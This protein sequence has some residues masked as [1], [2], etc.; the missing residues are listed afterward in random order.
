MLGIAWGTLD[1]LALRGA[2]GRFRVARPPE[3]EAARLAVVRD[4]PHGA[5][6]RPSASPR[7]PLSALRD[8]GQ[9]P[10]PLAPSLRR[11]GGGARSGFLG[12]LS[13]ELSSHPQ[14]LILAPEVGVSKQRG[15][16]SEWGASEVSAQPQPPYRAAV[17]RSL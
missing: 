1:E 13:M 5:D 4:S 9:R 14:S 12:V 10:S 2:R 15:Y 7:L 17:S 11:G 16:S 6:G 3:G 8:I